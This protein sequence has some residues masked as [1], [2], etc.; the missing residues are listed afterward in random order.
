[1]SNDIVIVE[2]HATSV[3]QKLEKTTDWRHRRDLMKARSH[4]ARVYIFTEGESIM[5]MF[6]NR[7]FRPYELYREQ[8]MPTI[9]SLLGVPDEEYSW[10][11]KAG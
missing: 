11:Q 10:S 6:G 4:K 2:A 8:V 3:D 5:A 1:M 9:M 7:H